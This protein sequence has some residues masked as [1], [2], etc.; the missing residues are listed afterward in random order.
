M[1]GSIS[2]LNVVLKVNFYSAIIWVT[3]TSARKNVF[4]LEMNANM[5]SMDGSNQPQLGA[6]FTRQDRNVN[7]F[8]RVQTTVEQAETMEF[9]PM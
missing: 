7:R 1:N 4:H 9:I 5:L 6:P 3:L 2:V 8:L